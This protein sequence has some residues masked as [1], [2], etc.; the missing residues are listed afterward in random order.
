[1]VKCEY[2]LLRYVPDLVKNEF[3]NFGLIMF[4]SS[5][6]GFAAVRFAK[7]LRRV[8]CLAPHVDLEVLHGMQ[9]DFARDLR[10]VTSRAE[11]LQMIKNNFSNGV[12]ASES[13]SCQTQSAE[14]E[15]EKLVDIYLEPSRIRRESRDLPIVGRPRI[16]HEM[17]ACLQRSEVLSLMWTGFPIAKYTHHGDPFEFDFGYSLDSTFKFLQAL[18][19]RSGPDSAK[20]LVF[21]FP[22]AQAGSR[23]VEKSDVTLTA[24]VENELD[25]KSEKVRFSLNALEESR[26]AVATVSEMPRLAEEARKDLRL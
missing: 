8:K 9:A 18:S 14:R 22:Q 4:D 26:I 24:V 15:L 13:F 2:M 1:M 5:G 23:R 25:R 7:D 16:L 17:K 6:T 12:Q 11:L 10:D 3:V 20:L 21:N 19:L